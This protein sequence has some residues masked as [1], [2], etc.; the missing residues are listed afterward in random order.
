MANLEPRRPALVHDYL[1][2]MRG[3]ERTFSEI[4]ACWPQAPIAC[5]LY[6]R[7]GT[8]GAFDGRSVR[9]SYLQRLHPSQAT[10]RFLLPLFP[11]AAERLDLGPADVVISSSSAFAHGVRPP[12]GVP[13]LCY[14]H[15]PFRYAWHER[16]RALQ[17]VPV[18]ARPAL[19][20]VLGRVRS[21]DVAAA[22]RVTSFLANSA[23]T[24]QRIADF[25]GRGAEVVHPPVA[26]ER[27]TPAADGQRRAYFLVV[28]EVVR[29]KRVQ[30][31]LEAARRAR[32]E[33]VVVGT[34]PDL[35]RLRT[36]YPEV[37]FRGRVSDQA[38]S[39]LYAH[40]RALVMANVEEFGI[41]AAEAQAAGCPV[42]AAAAGG[43]LETV[44][45][46]ETGVLVTP[47]DIDALAETMRYDDFTRFATRS[48]THN[49]A[50]FS[51]DRFR[52]EIKRAV[53]RMG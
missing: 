39:G 41:A 22:R 7:Q 14:C 50:R 17:E 38:L 4:A 24:Q 15:S 48:M 6:D 49:A 46:G 52:G 43:A 16:D 32:R 1:L 27:F 42:L 47:D 8:R 9:T 20:A 5:L 34:G 30:A 35:P 33:I 10:F 37:D 31:A 51:G 23:L 25:W 44:I 36:L 28:G 21:W 29:H 40:A 13:H 12:P 2:V 11:S 45:D 53:A 19:R 18:P 3:A 26:V